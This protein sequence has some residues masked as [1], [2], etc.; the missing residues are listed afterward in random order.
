MLSAFVQSESAR[1]M[2]LHHLLSQTNER[3]ESAEWRAI[4]TF[5]S[6]EIRLVEIKANI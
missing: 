2:F 3:S 6:N 1:Q 4:E 5:Y